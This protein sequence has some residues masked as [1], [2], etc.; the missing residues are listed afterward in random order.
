[1]H[2]H[3]HTYTAHRYCYW[4]L[5][6]NLLLN[7]KNRNITH[8]VNFSVIAFDFFFVVLDGK[9]LLNWIKEKK[10]KFS[11]NIYFFN[12]R[13]LLYLFN[14]IRI[15]ECSVL[16]AWTIT[17]IY[18]QYCP[19]ICLFLFLSLS[20]SLSLYIYIYIYIYITVK[21]TIQLSRLGRS[22]TSTSSQRN[23]KTPN[24]TSVQDITLNYLIE[25]LQ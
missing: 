4:E 19:S 15:L 16:N 24:P 12:D 6:F 18:E 25:R 14:W 13:I 20:L 5:P 23:S 11:E 7:I 8:E 17:N 10:K 22:N 21:S 9:N 2:T 3:I 1:M